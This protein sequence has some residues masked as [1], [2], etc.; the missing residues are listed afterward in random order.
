LCG[1]RPPARDQQSQPQESLC[2]S[3]RNTLIF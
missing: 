1:L 2:K 3:H